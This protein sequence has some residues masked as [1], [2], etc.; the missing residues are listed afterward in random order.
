MSRVNTGTNK[1]WL[2]FCLSHRTNYVYKQWNGVSMKSKPRNWTRSWMVYSKKGCPNCERT[3]IKGIL[4]KFD[5][6]PGAEER[7][8]EKVS[9]M[10][11]RQS[12]SP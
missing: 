4:E 11:S 2:R 7:P 3:E 9:A 10:T 8:P 1:V 12:S 5:H 6:A